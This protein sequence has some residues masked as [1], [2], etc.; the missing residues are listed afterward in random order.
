M[1]DDDPDRPGIVHRLDRDT[2]GVL[3]LAK[4]SAAKVYLQKL[5]HDRQISKTYIAL[6]VGRIIPAEAVI[7]LPLGRSPKRQTRQ[8]VQAEGRRAVTS[9]RV[10]EEYPGFTL[11]DLQPLTGR[12]HQIRAHL[13][14]IGHP[15]AGDRLYGAPAGPPGLQ[16]QFLHAARL[17][18]TGPNG[19]AIDVR[20]PLP[21]DLAAVLAALG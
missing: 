15:V 13:Q 2:S 14:A 5:F 8:A 7:E 17:Q 20:S 11:L 21:P 10:R 3:V 9:Y 4:T 19:Q 6:A 18:F 1:V 16:R 12:T